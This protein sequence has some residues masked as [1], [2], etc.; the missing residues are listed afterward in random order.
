MKKMKTCYIAGKIGGL[1]IEQYTANFEKAKQDILK[2]GLIPVSPL[3]LPHLHERSW[4]SYMKED[5]I[6]LLK[7]D[8]IYVLDNWIHS[9]G[10]KIEVN[11]ALAVGI[12]VIWEKRILKEQSHEI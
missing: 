4:E 5:L 7:C 12:Q 8:A 11:T 6:E 1:P 10:A 2:C 3:E 9:P